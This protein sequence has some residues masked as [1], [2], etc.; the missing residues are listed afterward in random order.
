MN[1]ENQN[2]LAVRDNSQEHSKE[3]KSLKKLH[4]LEDSLGNPFEK[5]IFC[6]PINIGSFSQVA[7]ILCYILWNQFALLLVFYRWMRIF[8]F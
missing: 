3:A 7:S 1:V 6:L 2:Q 4:D 8:N 5:W